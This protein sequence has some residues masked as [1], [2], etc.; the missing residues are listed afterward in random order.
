M[1][2]KIDFYL[3]QQP[4][5]LQCVPLCTELTLAQFQVGN[6]ITILFNQLESAQQVSHQLWHHPVTQFTPHILDQKT[7]R[8]GLARPQNDQYYTQCNMQVDTHELLP[9]I[10]QLIQII[11]NN[12]ADK[13]AARQLYRHFQQLG[14]TITLHKDAKAHG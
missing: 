3:A 11:P 7:N 5:F 2:L 1:A 13:T 14:H 9:K 8:I 6:D 10:N 12:D 4:S